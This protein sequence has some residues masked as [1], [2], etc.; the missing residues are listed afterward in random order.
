MGD[1]KNLYEKYYTGIKKDSVKKINNI[2]NKKDYRK[3]I[4]KQSIGAGV[5]VFVFFIIKNI[6]LEGANDVYIISKEIVSEN[7]NVTETVMAINIPALENYKEKTL[8]L[9]DSFKRL[10]TGG[11]TVKE[12]IRD[13]FILPIKGNYY[14]LDGE[15]VGLVIVVNEE[16]NVFCSYN[17]TVSKVE[18]VNQGT[19]VTINHG[20]GVETYYGLLTNVSVKVGEKVE[21]G[22]SIAKTGIIDKGESKGVVYKIIYMGIEKDP[23]DLLNI[24]NLESV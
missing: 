22:Q 15:N 1:Y 14:S 10:I 17:G 13:D 11:K 23:S 8:D 19:H 21:R 3:K 6:P 9:I 20:N 12:L 2:H 18:E 16:E 4:I 24:T 7:L 5:L